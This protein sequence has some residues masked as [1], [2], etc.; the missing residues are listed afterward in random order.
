MTANNEQTLE[1]KRAIVKGYR[2]GFCDHNGCH[3]APERRGMAGKGSHFRPPASDAYRDNYDRIFK[4]G[5][6]HGKSV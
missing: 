3:I 1:I 5:R 6:N 2:A 4:K